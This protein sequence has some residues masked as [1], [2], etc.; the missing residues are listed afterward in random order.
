M[1]KRF[2]TVVTILILISLSSFVSAQQVFRTTTTSVIPYLEY[3]PQDYAS[4]SD[5]YPVVFFLHG[6]SERCSNTTNIATLEAG[7]WTITKNGPPKL[8]KNGQQF[9]F[10]LISIQLKNNYS[11]WPTAYVLEVIN[12]V[13]TYLRIDERQMHITGLSMGGGGTWT[14]AEYY[15]ELFATASPI[16]GGYNAPSKAC[17]I[18]NE[19]LPVWTFHGDADTTVPYSKTVSMVN[20]INAC[21]PTPN[22]KAKLTI[23]PGVNHNAWDRAYTPNH[24]YHNPNLYEW[25]M[26]YTNIAK[27]SNKI[28]VT[29]ACTD[30]SITGNSVVITAAAADTDGTIASYSWKQIA[31]TACTIANGNTASAS[32]S[33]LAPGKSVFMVTATDNGGATDTDYVQ[34]TVG[35]TGTAP[36]ANAGADATLTLPTS[37]TSITGL[38]TDADGTISSYNWTF[39]SG[40]KTPVLTNASTARVTASDMTIAGNYVLKLEVKDNQGNTGTDHVTVIVNNT[41]TITSTNIKPIANAGSDITVYHPTTTATVT[42]TG[43]DADGTIVAY[44]WT[45]VSGPKASTLTNADQPIVSVSGLTMAGTYILKL[46]VTDDKGIAVLDK[47]VITVVA[48][49]L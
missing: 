18:A 32:L 16:C 48:G 4:N 7:V 8:V 1:I 34:V 46:N 28:P 23:Y 39:V 38:G 17:A 44:K 33:N 24:T 42:G 41:T 14:M 6:I 11:T 26:S 20:A 35:G 49:S 47:M 31:G 43:T 25:L 29:N 27:G 12:H 30:K 5:K 40:P 15:P 22:P 2:Y 37:T 21:L 3:V 45:Q 9:P 10:I 13:K 36:L 19:N